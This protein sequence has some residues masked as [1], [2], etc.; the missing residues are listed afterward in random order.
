MAINKQMQ[1]AH[2][3]ADRSTLYLILRV[4]HVADD[5]IA[6]QVYVDPEQLRLS[7]CLEF[8]AESYTVAPVQGA[9]AAPL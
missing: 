1:S 6:M 9:E 7:N 2:H 5:G 8:T 3:A 4:S